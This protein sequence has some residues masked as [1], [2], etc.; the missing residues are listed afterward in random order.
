MPPPDIVSAPTKP[1]KQFGN[2]AGYQYNDSMEDCFPDGHGPHR[3]Q[4]APRL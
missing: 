1:I 3:F 2:G 4:P